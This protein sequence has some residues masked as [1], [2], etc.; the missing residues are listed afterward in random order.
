M[1]L[2]RAN[3][4][5]SLVK[6]SSISYARKPANFATVSI[7]YS[8]S[9]TNVLTR[10]A[11]RRLW[12]HLDDRRLVTQRGHKLVVHDRDS[13]VLNPGGQDKVGNTRSVGER[14]YVAADLVERKYEVLAQRTGELRLRLVAN[15]HDGRIGVNGRLLVGKGA[16]G[17]LADGGVNTAAKTLVGGYD[18]EEL[19]LG[20]CLGG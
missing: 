9:S 14:G 16:A 13:V 5:R 2:A 8:H 4:E 7:G 3:S 18:E 12:A 19:A 1:A 17:E 20:G 10:L 11:E 15:N 6:S